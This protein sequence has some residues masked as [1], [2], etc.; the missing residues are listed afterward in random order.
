[1]MSNASIP[2]TP[3]RIESA[4]SA[5]FKILRILHRRL[6]FL[7]DHSGPV[8][9]RPNV[10]ADELLRVGSVLLDMVFTVQELRERV[11]QAPAEPDAEAWL[12]AQLDSLG[13][14][15]E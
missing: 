7:H 10:F 9:E 12:R 14:S 5:Q 1:M 15:Q 3:D 13:D 4:L 6:R 2:L 11:G 8:A